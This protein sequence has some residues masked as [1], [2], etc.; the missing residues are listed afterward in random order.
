MPKSDS[1]RITLED[2][3]REAR[4]S[5]QTVSRVVNNH[6]Y[7]SADT[8]RRVQDA[9]RKLDYRPNRAAR[10]LATQRSCMVGIIS[11]GMTHYGP[12]QMVNHIERTARTQGYGVSLSTVSTFSFDDI[13]RAM[14]DLGDRSVDGVLFI[15]PVTG[16]DYDDF[17]HIC[18][19]VPFVLIDTQLG[20]QMPSVVIDQ[21]Y[22]SQLAT[23][24]L[25]DLG[26]RAISAISGP[27]DWFGAQA[28]HQSWLDTLA[29][30]GIEPGPALEGDWTASSGYRKTRDLIKSGATFTALVAGNDQM[31]LGAIRALREAGRRVPEDVSVVGFD[32]IPEAAYFDPPLTTIRQDFA[33]LGKQSVEY[34]MAL[35][36]QPDLP[37][38]QR[39]LYPVFVARQSACK[40]GSDE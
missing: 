7:V 23:R 32:D 31:A 21:R 30:A 25:F 14:D 12:A 33:A 29:A 36:A 15:S 28:R 17:A 37:L 40:V 1:K 19:G 8:R 3:A 6:P 39:V 38:H 4:V 34:L 22:G 24:Y 16:A 35:I 26:H 27:L 20:A 9:I 18:G 11:F 10:N 2:V 13:R 5:A